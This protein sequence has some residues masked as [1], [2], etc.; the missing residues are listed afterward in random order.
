[1]VRTS[2]LKLIKAVKLYC[3]VLKNAREEPR[4]DTSLKVFSIAEG[5]HFALSTAAE[6]N[7]LVPKCLIGQYANVVLMPKERVDWSIYAE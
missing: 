5:P 7:N 6:M 2:F 1:M 4:D 3:S